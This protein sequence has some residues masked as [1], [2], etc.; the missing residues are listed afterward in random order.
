MVAISNLQQINATEILGNFNKEVKLFEASSEIISAV[1]EQ[2]IRVGLLNDAVD[3][4][5]G[6][7]TMTAFHKFKEL[8]YL[9]NPDVLGAT[10][11]AA[12]LEATAQHPQ[13]K[14]KEIPPPGEQL[15][16]IPEVGQIYS[17]QPVYPGCHF[18]WGEFTKGLTRVPETEQ[19]VRN[20]IKL[21]HHL[22]D[23]RSFLGDR[24][25]T[26]NSGYRP[27]AVNEAVGG[28]SNSRHLVGDA[29]D[30]VVD[31]MTPHEVFSRIDNWHGDK[32]GLG[33]S[34]SFTHIDLRGYSARWDYGNA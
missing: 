32:G 19:V 30:V 7:K 17:S 20:I 10:T 26:I 5:A 22:D 27:P 9:A 24:P 1:Q 6:E 12:L 11:A 25:I 31:G 13:P 2:L 14:D 23:M 3:G 21:A 4:I 18:S 28:V 29:A 34:A 15:I 8:E 33:D 16:R